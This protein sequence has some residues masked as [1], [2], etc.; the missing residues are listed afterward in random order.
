LVAEVTLSFGVVLLLML[1]YLIPR[2]GLVASF[3]SLYLLRTSDA[4]HFIVSDKNV[5]VTVGARLG[6]LFVLFHY[7]SNWLLISDN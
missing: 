6:L 7:S 4:V 2:Y 1:L 5:L 3:A